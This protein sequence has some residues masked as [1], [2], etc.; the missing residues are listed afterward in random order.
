MIRRKGDPRLV[1]GPLAAS[2]TVRRAQSYRRFI[3]HTEWITASANDRV[4]GSLSNWTPE[5][6]AEKSEL[7]GHS[8]IPR[9]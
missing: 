3:K 1:R 6:N 9:R 4:A 2:R 5:L 8:H 7:S